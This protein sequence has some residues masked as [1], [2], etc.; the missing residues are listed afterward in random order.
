M[1]GVKPKGPQ[2]AFADDRP[3]AVSLLRIYAWF[4]PVTRQPRSTFVPGRE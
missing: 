4:P 1:I 2:Q 3:A